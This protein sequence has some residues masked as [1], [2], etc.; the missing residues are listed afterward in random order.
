MLEHKNKITVI[1]LS[2]KNSISS[3]I[4]S[5]MTTLHQLHLNLKISI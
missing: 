2:N 5:V 3:D 4:K 1:S